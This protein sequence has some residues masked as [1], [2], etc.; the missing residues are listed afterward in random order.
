MN[1]SPRLR[2]LESQ[3]LDPSPRP[4]EV[5]TESVRYAIYTAWLRQ[6]S[7]ERVRLNAAARKL[8][9]EARRNPVRR[10]SPFRTINDLADRRRAR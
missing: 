2:R 8:A 6:D 3:I 10:E 1:T 5:P 9:A 7:V 4:L